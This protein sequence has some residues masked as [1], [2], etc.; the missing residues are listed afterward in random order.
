MKRSLFVKVILPVTLFF[1]TY[2]QVHGQ[3]NFSFG[4]GTGVMYYNGDLSDNSYIPSTKILKFF[5]GAEVSMFLVDR[6]DLSVRY[7]RGSVKGDDAISKENDNV[8]RNL[9][10]HSR[11]DEVSGLLRLRLFSVRSQRVVNP[12]G[13][14]GLGYFWFN[15]QAE[16]NGITY[17]L[18]PLGTEGQFIPGGGYAAP[19]KLQS[20]SLTFGLGAFFRL[21]NNF[22]LRLEFAP[23]LTFT[24]YLD[25]VS[26]IYPDSSLLSA[27]P[28]GNIAVLLSSRR[29]RGFP[30]EGRSRG[31]PNRGDVI[32]TFGASLVY[33]PPGKNKSQRNKP[34][35]FSQ[36]FKGRK[37]WWGMT[38]N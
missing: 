7:L 6:V 22:Q 8:A 14:F 28:N 2:L 34:G 27:T 26:T 16:L 24:D 20:S 32:V 19:Y 38:P 17:D 4:T 11:I 23:Q 21:N 36:F 30:K 35:V 15:P 9:S 12:Y 3:S 31:N 5:Y 29:P 37:G 1:L 10:F 33:T 18:Q 25:D 13:T